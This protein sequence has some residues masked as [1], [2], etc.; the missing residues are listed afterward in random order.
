[1]GRLLLPK[2]QLQVG[3][4]KS[5]Q[6]ICVLGKKTQTPS[7]RK[8]NNS[9]SGQVLSFQGDCSR[10][11]LLGTSEMTNSDVETCNGMIGL[12]QIRVQAGR[13]KHQSDA[14][15]PAV[16]FFGF[17]LHAALVS[18]A[19]PWQR[20]KRDILKY[21]WSPFASTKVTLCAS[22]HVHVGPSWGICKYPPFAV[23]CQGSCFS[24]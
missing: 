6:A 17:S 20:W 10:L 9:H 15:E 3:C 2:E 4:L 1:M 5:S 14:A 19:V 8:P 11:W 13:R 22:S 21:E 16:L 18:Q 7:I 23:C 24:K 12:V